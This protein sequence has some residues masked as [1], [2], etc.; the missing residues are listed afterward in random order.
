MILPL[1]SSADGLTYSVLSLK[2]GGNQ[3]EGIILAV[4]TGDKTGWTKPQSRAELAAIKIVKQRHSALVR[5]WASMFQGERRAICS[6][7]F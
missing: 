3:V 4:A 5:S 7:P 1:P 6:R 2:R